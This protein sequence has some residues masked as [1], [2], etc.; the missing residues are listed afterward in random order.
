MSALTFNAFL[1]EAL[2]LP[3]EQRSRLA[4]VLIDSLD[5]DDDAKL[6]PAWKAEVVRRA[7]ELDDGSVLP[8]SLDEFRSRIETQ[9]A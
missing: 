1:S 6:T 8:L 2:C 5:A 7:S 4:T 3:V 9:L